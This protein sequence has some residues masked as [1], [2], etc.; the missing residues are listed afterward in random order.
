MTAATD[1]DTTVDVDLSQA[2]PCTYEECDSPATCRDV[3][4]CPERHAFNFCAAHGAEEAEYQEQF[5][6]DLACGVCEQELP[7]PHATWRNL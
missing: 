6:D 7:H 1:V 4:V 5:C 2:I 3:N